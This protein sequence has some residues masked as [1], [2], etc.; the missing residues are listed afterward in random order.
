MKKQKN[1]TKDIESPS[2][3]A[4]SNGPLQ[5]GSS[6][7]SVTDDTWLLHPGDNKMQTSPPGDNSESL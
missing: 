3:V 4:L 6:F 7:H 1:L 2:G 5:K